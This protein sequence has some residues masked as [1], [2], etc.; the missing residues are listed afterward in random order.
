MEVSVQHQVDALVAEFC[1]QI[2]LLGSRA[3]GLAIQNAALRA[4]LEELRG[5]LKERASES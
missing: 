4:E 2:K 5:K 3:A 1:E